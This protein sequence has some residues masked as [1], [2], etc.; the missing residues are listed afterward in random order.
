MK[1]FFSPLVELSL[2]YPRVGLGLWL[3]VIT[4]CIAGVSKL[5]IAYDYRSFFDEAN[6]ELTQFNEIEQRYT[7]TD[8]VN[9]I[10]HRADGDVFN[11]G[12][13]EA[14]KTLT[15]RALDIPHSTRSQS[16]TNFQYSYAD[17]DDLRVEPLIAPLTNNAANAL[18]TIKTRAMG[19]P[20][21]VGRLLSPDG[22]SAQVIVTVRLPTDQGNVL[23]QIKATVAQIKSDVLAKAPD[24]D[25]AVTGVV[26]LSNAFFDITVQ[27]MIR[28]FPI[29]GVLVIG[30]LSWFFASL[31]AAGYCLLVISLSIGMAMGVAGWFGVALTPATGPVPVVIMTVALVDSVHIMSTFL[32]L[33]R[34][35]DHHSAVRQAVFSNLRPIVLTS[36]TTAVG[37][38][39]LNFSD[40]PPFREFGNIAALGTVF[41][42]LAALS[43]LPILLKAPAMARTGR[44]RFASAQGLASF[45][46]AVRP[47]R[48]VIVAAALAASILALWAIRA[49][50]VEDNFVEWIGADQ[51]F[52]QDAAFIQERLPALFTLQFSVA[53]PDDA[54]V[55]NPDYLSDL[56]Q[57]RAYV[58]AANGVSHVASFDQIM[59]RLNR[60]LNGDDQAFDILPDS[61]ELAA[62][63][64][65][66]YELSLPFGEDLTTLLTIKRDAARLV[67]T[68]KPQTSRE[69]RALRSDILAWADANLKH[70]EV[71]GGTGTNMIFAEV[72]A[73]N[74]RSMFIGSMVAAIGIGLILM[75]ALRTWQLGILSLMPNIIPALMAFGLWAFAVGSV[76]LYGAFV[77][78][79][80]LGLVVDATVHILEKYTSLKTDPQT[81]DPVA[82]TTAEVGPA[83]L[84]SSA[85]LMTGFGV[86]TVSAFA[87]IGLL[88]QLVLLTLAVALLAD[89]IMLPALLYCVRRA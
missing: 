31:R 80:S 8:S 83:I 27:D 39:S 30:V 76:G 32:R 74:T 57:L 22:Q 37:F 54:S 47:V 29:M 84:I 58:E 14:L 19:E 77:V 86:L 41:A 24:L 10:L 68:L 67:A 46:Q 23:P 56:A 25:I 48:W 13:L 26:M 73:S 71:S 79:V 17:G 88:S 82:K 78:S 51:P 60:N 12:D 9:F 89:F 69:M 5:T 7:A 18:K 52:R 20:L 28:L 64:L 53:A 11:K 50:P 40:T 59:R 70:T 1:R 38:L 81:T 85:V 45:T 87:L 75:V 43:L 3:V 15:D 49:M 36:I 2:R 66:L 42:G 35:S 33:R 4:L 65:L 44:D 16:L 21:V 61:A 63:Y 55:T 62:Q 34:T 72:T 6:P